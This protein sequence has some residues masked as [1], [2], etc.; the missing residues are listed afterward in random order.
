MGLENEWDGGGGGP[1]VGGL[2]PGRRGDASVQRSRVRCRPIG[3]MVE[4]KALTRA[5]H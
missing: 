1:W 3:R 2:Y 5:K 4:G